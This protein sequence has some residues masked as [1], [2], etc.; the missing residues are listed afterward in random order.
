MSKKRGDA[1]P[2]KPALSKAEG[3]RRVESD[4]SPSASPRLP[5]PAA[6]LSELSSHPTVKNWLAAQTE[7]SDHQLRSGPPGGWPYNESKREGVEALNKFLH[8]LQNLAA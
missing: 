8:A 6:S 3:S 5:L 1:V 4:P 7:W 2:D